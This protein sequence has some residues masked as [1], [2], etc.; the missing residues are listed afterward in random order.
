MLDI[1]PDGL[2]NWP[3]LLQ[4]GNIENGFVLRWACNYRC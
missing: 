4:V 1:S 3:I 2:S